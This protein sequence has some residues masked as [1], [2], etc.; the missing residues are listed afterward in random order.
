M[1]CR[2]EKQTSHA[3]FRK[4]WAIVGLLTM[5]ML[6]FAATDANHARFNDLGHRMMCTCG[7][8]QVLLECNH[9]GCTAS[10]KMRGELQAALDKGLKDQGVLD[11]FVQKYGATVLNAPTTHGLNLVAWIMPFAA[12]LLATWFTVVFIRKWKERPEESAGVAVAA[13]EL[14]GADIGAL[15]KQAREETEV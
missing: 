5:I 11:E 12:L 2:I 4:A 14:R 10:D 7:C 9:V 13:A 1:N 15:R 6:S 8:N 3:A